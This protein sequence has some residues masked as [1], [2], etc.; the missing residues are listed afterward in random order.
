[1]MVPLTSA[2]T[3]VRLYCDQTFTFVY[4]LA[5]NY[6]IQFLKFNHKSA[7]FLVDH[8]GTVYKRYAPSTPPFDMKEDIE[9]LLEKRNNSGS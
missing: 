5:S 2:G 4:G 3:L 1:M 6:A 9:M 8:E 7:K